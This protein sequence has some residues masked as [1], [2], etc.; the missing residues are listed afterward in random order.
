M[1]VGGTDEILSFFFFF[2]SWAEKCS[3]SS[4]MQSYSWRLGAQRPHII[5]VSVKRRN[6]LSVDQFEGSALISW[7]IVCCCGQS[8]VVSVV[9]TP[10]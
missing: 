3:G 4:L 9:C 7:R 5:P 2:L 1:A 8:V 6:Y 10:K